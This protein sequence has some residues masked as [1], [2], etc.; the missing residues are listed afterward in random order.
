M[1]YTKQVWRRTEVAVTG[2]TRNQ[3]TGF[4]PVRGFESLRLRVTGT[5]ILNVYIKI[6]VPVFSCLLALPNCPFTQV[7]L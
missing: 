7:S 2:L 3:F 4:A 5:I 6:V 1:C